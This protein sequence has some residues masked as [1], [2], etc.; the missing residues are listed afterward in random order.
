MAQKPKHV[1]RNIVYGAKRFYPARDERELA[2]CVASR[3]PGSYQHYQPLLS[4]E[5]K[6]GNLIKTVENGHPGYTSIRAKSET[7]SRK[8]AERFVRTPNPAMAMA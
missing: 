4:A 6:E 7:T 5:I 1:V 8:K 2:I 3:Y